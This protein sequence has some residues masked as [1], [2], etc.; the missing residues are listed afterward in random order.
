[1]SLFDQALQVIA[2]FNA[3]YIVVSAGFDAHKD[4]FIGKQP[5]I[6]FLDDMSYYELGRRICSL[7]IA[8]AIV[9][10]GGYNQKVTAN[11]FFN[12][13]KGIGG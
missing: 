1:M 12:F 9:F 6:T 2:N 7:N 4:D 5:P 10:E 3:D 11:A 13:M 8:R